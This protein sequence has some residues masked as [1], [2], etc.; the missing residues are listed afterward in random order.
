MS[1]VT[2]GNAQTFLYCYLYCFRPRS[3]LDIHAFVAVTTQ[4]NLLFMTWVSRVLEQSLTKN[5]L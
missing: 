4:K 1:I 2:I 3:G 5:I